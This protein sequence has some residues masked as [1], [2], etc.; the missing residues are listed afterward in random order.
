MTEHNSGMPDFLQLEVFRA[1]TRRVLTMTRLQRALI[2][3]MAIASGIICNNIAFAAENIYQVEMIV[4]ERT[5]ADTDEQWPKNLVL[6]YPGHWQR[7][8]DPAAEAAR[9]AEAEAATARTDA[10][11]LSDDFLQTLANEAA[12]R[13]GTEASDFSAATPDATAE[14]PDSLAGTGNSSPS[15]ETTAFFAF[16]PPQQRTL[17]KTRAALDR[18]KQLRVVFH[19]AWRQPLT[20]IEKSPALIFHGGNQFG[21][22]Y[23]L[24]G[25]IH[26]GISRYLHLQT[27]LWFTHFAPNHGQSS[28][29]WPKLPTEPAALTGNRK[30][31]SKSAD[32]TAASVYPTAIA[33]DS[34]VVP[35]P[36]APFGLPGWDTSS[37]EDPYAALL[38]A[39]YVINQIAT[40]RQKRR[41]R[42]G[43]LHYID[44][45]QIGLLIKFTP[46]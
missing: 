43:E 1:T 22:N 25:Y 32:P 18:S 12:D 21:A 6:E 20:A 19:E 14:N 42:S 24:Q 3:A 15:A 16:L 30:G 33:G 44:H 10:L 7:L 4:F 5:T 28:E 13:R 29:H 31:L 45:P 2:T 35:Q 11:R 9:Q 38:E 17:E 8:F 34:A 41:M 46:I 39:P 36:D 37:T 23:E 27:N 26:L 40:L